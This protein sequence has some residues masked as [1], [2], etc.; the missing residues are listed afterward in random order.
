[1]EDL[2]KYELEEKGGSSEETVAVV[3]EGISICKRNLQL[4]TG[5][6]GKVP[7]GLDWRLHLRDIQVHQ[8]GEVPLKSFLLKNKKVPRKRFAQG[9]H[10]KASAVV[11]RGSQ[12][13]S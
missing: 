1:M 13:T 4:C 6:V 12:I 8:R 5:M 10:T 11:V 2:T 9:H 7:S 3:V